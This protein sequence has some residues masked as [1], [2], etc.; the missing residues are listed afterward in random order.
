MFLVGRWVTHGHT[1]PAKGNRY[2]LY[3]LWSKVHEDRDSADCF[4]FKTESH[5]S[6]QGM[7][8]GI[9]LIVA[10]L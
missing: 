8:A 1:F 7:I 4:D 5:R 6:E 3:C 10:N 2:C 9:H